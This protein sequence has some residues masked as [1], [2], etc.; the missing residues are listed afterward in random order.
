MNPIA[1]NLNSN[2]HGV[3]VVTELLFGTWFVDSSRYFL[4][5]TFPILG[6]RRRNSV[7]MAPLDNPKNMSWYTIFFAMTSTSKIHIVGDLYMYY[8]SRHVCKQ[9]GMAFC[10]NFFWYWRR[11]IGINYT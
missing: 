2:E 7:V 5:D 4:N 9:Y 6:G 8:G 3:W 1:K 10:I 11:L